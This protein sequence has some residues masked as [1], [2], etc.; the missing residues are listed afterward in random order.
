[1]VV[2]D[3]KDASGDAQ[4]YTDAEENQLTEKPTPIPISPDRFG[5]LIERR[6][7]LDFPYYTG[8]P[9][10]ISGHQWWLV[11]AAVVVGFAALTT[12]PLTGPV[13]SFIPAILFV[14]IPLLVLRWVAPTGWTA[15]FRRVGGRDILVMIGFAALNVVVTFA[16]GAIVAAITNATANPEAGVLADASTLERVVFYPRT[17]IQLLGEELLTILPFL[18]LLYFLVSKAGWSRKHAVLLSWLVTAVAFGL[19]HLPT[20]DWNV[21]QCIVV[22]G[23]ARVILTLAYIRTK[24]IWVSTGAH[25]LNDW[26][27]FSI[28]M[29]TAG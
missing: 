24:N 20:Y 21:L 1:M 17:A 22:I 6:D 5:R 9:V 29:L 16:L 28:P 7:G 27:L 14:A 19:V 3:L 12:L 11:I 25:I 4:S 2:S 10:L 26:T 23:G 13:L 18:A 15:I 8:R